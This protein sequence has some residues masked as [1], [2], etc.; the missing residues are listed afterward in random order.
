MGERRKMQEAREE[1]APLAARLTGAEPL[2]AGWRPDG[3]LAVI[4]ADGRKWVFVRR[5]DGG[6]ERRP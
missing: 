3:S 1:A 6:W 2:A 4:G 5:A